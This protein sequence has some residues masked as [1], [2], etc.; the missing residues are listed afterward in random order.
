MPS[1]AVRSLS[2]WMS[3]PLATVI[4]VTALL[5]LPI[6]NVPAVFSAPLTSLG[7]V[8]I[9]YKIGFEGYLA[10]VPDGT[11]NLTF[12]VYANKS[13]PTGNNIWSETQAV[14]VTSGLYS[15]VLGNYTPITPTVVFVNGPRWIGVTVD[16]GT[17]ITPRTEVDSVPFAINADHA[18]VAESA[19]SAPWSGV[20]GVSAVTGITVGVNNTLSL[21][22]GYQLPQGCVS[23]QVVQSNGSSWGCLANVV[24][25]TA[26]NGQVAVWGPG[27]SVTGSSGLVAANGALTVTNSI[28]VGAASGANTGDVRAS[29]TISTT[30]GLDV[31]TASGATAG[32]IKSSGDVFAA[33]KATGL[34]AQ[35]QSFTIA[36]A[37]NLVTLTTTF[38]DAPGVTTTFTAVT[39]GEFMVLQAIAYFDFSK[40]TAGC[41]AGDVLQA[42]ILEDGTLT[43]SIWTIP[44]SG[45]SGG[46]EIPQWF[47]ISLAAGSHTIKL[48]VRNSTGARGRAGTQSQLAYWRIPQ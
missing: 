7:V 44:A 46:A 27:N 4:L 19:N 12:Q 38:Q 39:G 48:Q 26:A 40:G 45:N 16:T 2:G 34:Q 24:T 35:F 11:H 9:P 32:Q 21:L 28:N 25:G 13:D 20:T 47:K 5:V 1:R 3:S 42:Q 6:A 41:S 15:V 23:G 10:N 36:Q 31:G 14:T 18:N 33:G 37:T 29:G 17:E 30:G 22:P 43:G 8:S